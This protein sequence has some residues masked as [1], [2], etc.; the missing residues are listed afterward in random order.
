M[1]VGC[2]EDPKPLAPPALPTPPAP[3]LLPEGVEPPTAKPGHHGAEAAQA[4]ETKAAP[5]PAMPR[6]PSA[7]P[8]FQAPRPAH[9]RADVAHPGASPQPRENAQSAPAP[10]ATAVLAG[11]AASSKRVNVPR[12][13]NVHIEYPSGLQTDLD[14]DPRM[15]T[16]VNR[17]VPIIDGCH[18]RN[19]ALQ[20]IVEAQVTM[21]E[22]ERP[23]ATLRSLPGALSAIVTCA[24]LALMQVKMPL[25]TGQEG[26]RYTVRVVFEGS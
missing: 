11:P 22:N 25:F 10:V 1:L 18:A 7:Q 5:H 15:Q 17:V 24:T 23:E 8:G 3:A 19:R 6:A 12:T 2:G 26:T 9:R 14:A 20:G 21:H 13:A 4:K 16:W